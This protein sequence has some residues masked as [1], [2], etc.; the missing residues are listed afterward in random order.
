MDTIWLDNMEDC[1]PGVSIVCQSMVNLIMNQNHQIE[2]PVLSWFDSSSINMIPRIKEKLENK[3]IEK[4][5]I[6]IDHGM[7]R[8]DLLFGNPK[9]FW[10]DGTHPNRLGHKILFDFLQTQISGL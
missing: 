8:E 4:L 2:T 3:E 1:Y 5:L 9:Y 6:M 7:G 10:P